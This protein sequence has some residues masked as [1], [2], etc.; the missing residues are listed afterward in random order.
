MFLTAFYSKK[1]IWIYDQYI[2]SYEYMYQIYI[3]TYELE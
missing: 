1:Y 3:Y 2:Y